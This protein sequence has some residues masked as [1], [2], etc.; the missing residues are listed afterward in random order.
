M[1]GMVAVLIYLSSFFSGSET[2]LTAASKARIH[3][4]EKNGD[5]RAIIVSK[6]L[7]SRERLLGGILLGNN[8]VN[9][10]ASVLTTAIFTN[11]LG[12]GGFALMSATIVMTLLILIFAEVLPKSYAISQPDTLALK[13]AVR[14]NF[15][16]KVFA[17]MVLIIQI[18]VNGT[19]R[20]FGVNS[21]SGSWSAEDAIKGAV[22]LHLEE[23]GVAKRA[24]DQIYGV[25]EIGELSVEEVMIH[26]KNVCMIDINI[27][28]K[29]IIKE[30]LNSGHSRVPLYENGQDN[31]IGVLHVKDILK[32]ISSAEVVLSEIDTRKIMRNTWFVPETTSLVKQLK[33]FQQKREHFAV[34]VDEYGAL[35]GIVT[36]EDILEEIVGDIQDEYDEEIT[37]INKLKEGGAIL[38]G[39]LTVRDVNRAMGWGLPDEEAVTIAGLVIYESQTIPEVNQTF[40]YHGYRFEVIKKQRNQI[41]SLK[42]NKIYE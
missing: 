15:I 14:V 9:I 18:I 3:N 29:E 20:L 39:N 36:L 23:G 26:R 16:V 25:L 30:V 33:A 19:L 41:I 34:V 38:R 17:P 2:A 24:R 31:I 6:L 28:P 12:G 21:N 40:S 42:V 4:L 1:I 5:K 32:S 27:P 8:L 22:D 11:I 35:M 10:L 37:G 13:V 7:N